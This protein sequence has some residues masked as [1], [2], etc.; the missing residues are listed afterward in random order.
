MT[1]VISITNPSW[2]GSIVSF[3]ANWTTNLYS[4]TKVLE[5]SVG[6]VIKTELTGGVYSGGGTTQ[7]NYSDTASSVTLTFKL[8]RLL[9]GVKNLVV[10]GYVLNY[11]ITKTG[12]TTL[13]NS[14]PTGVTVTNIS[15]TGMTISWNSS[16]TPSGWYVNLNSATKATVTVKTA[17]ITGLLPNTSY[18]VQVYSFV[19]SALSS[20]STTVQ[21]STLPTS[22]T[23]PSAP[24]LSS[25][26]IDQNNVMVYCAPVANATW[27]NLEAYTPQYPQW[28][29]LVPDSTLTPVNNEIQ[30]PVALGSLDG[31]YQYRARARNSAGYSAYSNVVTITKTTAPVVT[32]PNAPVI[33][34]SIYGSPDIVLISWNGI[35]NATEYNLEVTSPLLSTFTSITGDFNANTI[36]GQLGITMTLTAFGQYQFRLRAKN[37][38]GYSNYSNILTTNYNN[39]VPN[40]TIPNAP[41]LQM[42]VSSLPNNKLLKWNKDSNVTEYNL[43]SSNPLTDPLWMSLTGDFMTGINNDLGDNNWG[44][45]VVMGTQD[46]LWKYR[47]RAK[48]SIGYSNYSNVVSYTITNNVPEPTPTNEKN[49]LSMFSKLFAM[50]TG[51]GLLVAKK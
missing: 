46:G 16:T 1:T 29:E 25:R 17:T 30:F 34:S 14:T 8:W 48:N 43:E 13:T 35:T 6:G 9:N 7:F 19:G 23:A 20:P 27:Y 4:E 40:P 31:N 21:V 41:V 39:P 44:I 15:S 33:S 49:L 18:N 24:V 11:P 12:G 51:L 28:L 37:S 10:D 45:N 22:T 47:I 50:G 42:L 3:T 32:V 38:T 5:V 2:D 36:N 26:S